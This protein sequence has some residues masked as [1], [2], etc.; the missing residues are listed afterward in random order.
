MSILSHISEQKGQIAILIDPDK[1]SD[2]Y[3][4]YLVDIANKGLAHYFLVGG[5]L[6]FKNQLSQIIDFLKA[7]TSIPII[8]FPGNPSQ[9]YENAD[10]LLF[11]S[12]IS[13]RNA[14]LLIGRHVEAAPIIKQTSLEVIP[15]GYILI[16][17]EKST[18]VSY[19]SNTT[20]IPRDK[21]DIA[22]ATAM[23]G[24]MLG[25]KCIYLEAG[26]GAE[27]PVP[28]EM[29]KKVRENIDIPIIVGGGLRTK[30]QIDSAI[31]AGANLIILGSIIEK[32]LGFIYSLHSLSQVNT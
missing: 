29:I 26:S 21:S 14:D 4:L 17:G 19:I 5:S 16:D 7:H 1:C 25:L 8:I 13:G 27:K 24:E 15:T 18:S 20:P 28:A 10:G 31:E 23:A 6:I 30:T 9:V 12:L 32:D 2:N 11:L 3:L 22:V